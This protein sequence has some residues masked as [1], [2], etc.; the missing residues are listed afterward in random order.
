[1]TYINQEYTIEELTSIWYETYIREKMALAIRETLNKFG[2]SI[3]DNSTISSAYKFLGNE[4]SLI[5]HKYNPIDY[6]NFNE[7]DFNPV[8]LSNVSNVSKEVNEHFLKTF[9]SV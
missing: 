7:A 8:R 4:F 2:N 6:D 1:M 3:L 5:K 9:L